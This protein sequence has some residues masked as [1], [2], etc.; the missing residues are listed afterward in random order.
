MNDLNKPQDSEDAGNVSN[1]QMVTQ[2]LDSEAQASVRRQA[3]DEVVEAERDAQHVH[4]L[5]QRHAVAQRIN[6][7]GKTAKERKSHSWV[8]STVMLLLIGLLGWAGYNY[9]WK[10]SGSG[11][12]GGAGGTGWV[13]GTGGADSEAVKS[14]VDQWVRSL[15][16]NLRYQGVRYH[17]YHVA[18]DKTSP[19]GVLLVI[20]GSV[21]AADQKLSQEQAAKRVPKEKVNDEQLPGL[22]KDR[23]RQLAEGVKTIRNTY[24]P[25]RMEGITSMKS[26]GGPGSSEASD[27]TGKTDQQQDS[28]LRDLGFEFDNTSEAGKNS[29]SSGQSQNNDIERPFVLVV[30]KD[31]S[32]A[33]FPSGI[34]LE[35]FIWEAQVRSGSTQLLKG[36]D[37]VPIEKVVNAIFTSRKQGTDDYRQY[38]KVYGQS[39]IDDLFPKTYKPDQ[40]KLARC[41]IIKNRSVRAFVQVTD[42]NAKRTGTWILTLLRL[43]NDGQWRVARTWHPR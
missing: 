28:N 40:W 21:H 18:I 25:K 3:E 2:M 14:L 17:I 12:S 36:N 22:T 16:S 13:G 32:T 8:I 38:L 24:D 19:K 41:D 31:E 29:T 6:R 7:L 26:P 9:A 34:A 30:R 4:D 5:E 11:G 23:K 10:N 27:S 15:S 33:S 1:E 37:Q 35:Y 39:H 43:E 42:V 20:N